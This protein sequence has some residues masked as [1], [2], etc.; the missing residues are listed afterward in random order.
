M[1]II[2]S[3]AVEELKKENNDGG[4]VTLTW[5]KPAGFNGTNARY[6]VA[7]NGE[8]YILSMSQTAYTIQ[9]KQKDES[10]TVEVRTYLM[11]LFIYQEVTFASLKFRR[12]VKRKQS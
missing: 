3:P 1:V 12:A 7:Y 2:E 8:R 4:S 11:F 10:F 6:V 5:K 9:S